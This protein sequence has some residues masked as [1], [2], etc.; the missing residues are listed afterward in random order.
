METVYKNLD[1]LKAY[2]KISEKQRHGLI[3][4]VTDEQAKLIGE[5]AANILAKTLSISEENK[6]GLRRHRSII[7]V[8]GSKDSSSK[9]RVNSIKRNYKVAA[10]LLDIT[11]KK[12]IKII[13]ES[14]K[15]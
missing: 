8:L 9:K 4:N 10:K 11:A 15:K 12:L 13:Q 5:I 6:L 7:R 14:G 3:K 1:F 2:T